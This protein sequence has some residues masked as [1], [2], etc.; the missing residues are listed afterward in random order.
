[1]QEQTGWIIRKYVDRVHRFSML[2]LV[3]SLACQYVEVI[4]QI[5]GNYGR[6]I[7]MVHRIQPEPAGSMDS[8]KF[9]WS[10]R[11]EGE[12]STSIHG[13]HR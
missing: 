8:L 2:G 13:V 4:L 10:V 3:W 6:A 11:E 9:V 1:M 12:K 7:E 5:C